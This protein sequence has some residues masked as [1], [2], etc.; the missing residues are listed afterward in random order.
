MK[1]FRNKLTEELIIVFGHATD[2][3]HYAPESQRVMIYS[4]LKDHND[5][6]TVAQKF[7]KEIVSFQRNYEE[8]EYINEYD[9]RN[10][11]IETIKNTWDD[12]LYKIYH[13]LTGKNI[14]DF[15]IVN[16]E[17]FLIIKD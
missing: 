17:K 1:I 15:Y 10:E 7:V 14:Q 13:M 6:N 8:V 12:K 5:E 4:L 2:M 11:L 3:S 9:L 16:N